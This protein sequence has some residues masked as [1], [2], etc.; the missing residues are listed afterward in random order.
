MNRSTIN[1]VL[2]TLATSITIA[3]PALAKVGVASVV[4][5]EPMSR[6]PAET[7]RVL[8][9]GSDMIANELVT[10]KAN[11]RAHLVFLD[12][13][14]LTVGPSSSVSI[15]RFVYDPA[16]KS[17]ELNLRATRGVFRYVGGAIS[18]GSEVTINTP[19]ATIGIRGGIAT[20]TV[21]ASGSTRADFL[22]GGSMSIT[23]QGVTRTT[24]QPGTQIGVST[25]LP[26]SEPAPIPP[27]VLQQTTASLQSSTQ[28]PS[29][30]AATISQVFNGA[31]ITQMNSSMSPAIARAAVQT[32]VQTQM[33]V[34]KTSPQLGTSQ[35]AG[36]LQTAGPLQGSSPLLSTGP[37]QGIGSLQNSGP[38]AAATPFQQT[39]PIATDSSL[40]LSGV[41]PGMAVPNA[42]TPAVAALAMAGDTGAIQQLQNTL[43]SPTI[44]PATLTSLVSA[45]SQPST[46]TTTT[47]TSTPTGSAAPTP[48]APTVYS[49]PASANVSPN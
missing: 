49:S 44:S 11:D 43:S 34:A 15:D 30:A 1:R 22:F 35:G 45:V 9:V 47:T 25:G 27:A 36:L 38:L 48:L 10:T 33:A 31:P 2:L 13:S 29:A 4:N 14:T 5:G 39:G 46:T 3:Q 8:R 37:T 12:G 19:S 40:A 20:V 42:P 28:A 21:D 17:G 18:K 16:T 32:T 6:P 7:E 23:S 26:P 41:Q 24:T